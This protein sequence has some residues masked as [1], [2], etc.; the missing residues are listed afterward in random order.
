MFHGTPCTCWQ[1]ERLANPL[2][3][4]VKQTYPGKY[5]SN[6]TTCAGH[7][8]RYGLYCGTSYVIYHR[9]KQRGFDG[10]SP[11]LNWIQCSMV[12]EVR[13]LLVI[14]CE[15]AIIFYL[16]AWPARRMRLRCLEQCQGGEQFR[17]RSK[18]GKKWKN[19]FS[20]WFHFPPRL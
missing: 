20:F 17:C 7:S 15:W 13:P 4:G 8:V 2:D 3:L 12:A 1:C 9:S 14:Q 16:F 18:K 11:R 19:W 5:R 6:G 10:F